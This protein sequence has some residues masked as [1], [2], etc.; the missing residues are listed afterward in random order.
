MFTDKCTPLPHKSF[1]HA[2][3][4][5]FADNLFQVEIL[6]VL[7]NPHVVYQTCEPLTVISLIATILNSK[8]RICATLIQYFEFSDKHTH[9]Q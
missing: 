5:I 7:F 1:T 8:Y 2:H 6:G 3:D 9:T 4:S